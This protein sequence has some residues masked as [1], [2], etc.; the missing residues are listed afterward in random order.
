MTA[1]TTFRDA[2]EHASDYLGGNPEN[3]TTRELRRAIMAAN[4]ELA[5]LHRWACRYR[6]GHLNIVA[7][8]QGTLTYTHS[9]RTFTLVENTETW[10]AEGTIRVANNDYPVLRRT[11]ATTLIADTSINPGEDL[12][13]GTAYTLYRDMW[14]LPA[15]FIAVGRIFPGNTAASFIAAPSQFETTKLAG[16][17][18]SPLEFTVVADR[19]RPG[20]VAF[21][22]SPWPSTDDAIQFLYQSEAR[23]LKYTGHAL[24]DSL[25]TVTVSG[26]TVTG[27]GTAFEADMVGT[28][29][30]AANPN[31]GANA[32]KIPSDDAGDN[33]AYVEGVV[34][35]VTNSLELILLE[36]ET[37]I[38]APVKYVVS[39]PIDWSNNLLNVFFRCCE[40]Q[41]EIV[42]QREGAGKG[43]AMALFNDALDD[44]KVADRR[45]FDATA[46]GI[47]RDARMRE[48]QQFV[49][50]TEIS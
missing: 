6:V 14:T 8:L 13:A 28:V 48:Y 21:K 49:P 24:R 36:N 5:G 26:T 30:R 27:I 11:A 7:P 42:R 25:G 32:L 43:D 40:K 41:S 10:A 3:Q 35:A 29:F 39:D 1:M 4:R 46:L 44:A 18:G 22:L 9:T 23:D 17:A 38:T 45:T 12:A 19:K 33:P 37:N 16:S 34:I 50:L 20:R 31:A 2:L 47:D 15:D